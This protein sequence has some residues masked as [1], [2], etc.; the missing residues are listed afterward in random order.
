MAGKVDQH[1]FDS[2]LATK[3]DLTTLNDKLK[4]AADF[5]AFKTSLV[6]TFQLLIPPGGFIVG[7][8]GG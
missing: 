3:L 5:G 7:P 4:D 8:P 1:T 6:S 2:A